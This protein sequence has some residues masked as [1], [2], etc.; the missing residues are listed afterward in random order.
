MLFCVMGNSGIGKREIVNGLKEASFIRHMPVVTDTDNRYADN[1]IGKEEFD[2]L[3]AE[4]KLI[5]LDNIQMVQ[6]QQF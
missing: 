5:A 2:K 1:Y 3:E 6:E 4:S